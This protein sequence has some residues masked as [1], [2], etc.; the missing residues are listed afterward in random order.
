MVLFYRFLHLPPGVTRLKLTIRG[1]SVEIKDFSDADYA[2]VTDLIETELANKK[3]QNRK[4]IQNA[5][6]LALQ[7]APQ[8][9]ASD[10]WHHVIYRR[11]R[12]RVKELRDIDDPINSWVRA[13]GDALEYFIA[14]YYNDL[15]AKTDVRLI[16]LTRTQKPQ[17]LKDMGIYGKVGDSKLDIAAVHNCTI[18][19]TPTLDRGIFGGIHVKASLAERVSDDVPCSVAM[20][21]KGYF[22]VLATLDVKSFPKS[23]TTSDVRAYLNN[24]ELGSQANP[25]DKRRYI[26]EHGSFDAA[27]S[28]NLRT[29]ATTKPTTSGKRIFVSR[30]DGKPDALVEMLLEASKRR[31]AIES[32]SK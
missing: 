29:N 8:A 21:E 1:L 22:S 5:F 15:L 11:Y 30:F 2:A 7:R 17:A 27:V 9:N 10:I 16:A 12:D 32:K 14:D 3:I 24:G 19:M 31:K 20:M 13:S 26:E 4:V 23:G 28:Y 18:G 6:A 25:S